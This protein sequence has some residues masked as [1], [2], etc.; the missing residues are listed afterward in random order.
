M[1][2]VLYSYR[3]ITSGLEKCS[4]EFEALV[5][6]YRDLYQISFDAD[7][8]TLLSLLMLQQSCQVRE[9]SEFMGWGAAYSANP[10]ISRE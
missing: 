9:A 6:A 3:H 2:I 8:A 10:Y 7:P 5:V 1:V 4:R